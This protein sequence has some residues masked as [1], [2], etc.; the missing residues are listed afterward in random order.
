MP[1][2]FA[3][4]DDSEIEITPGMI[5]A[6]ASVLCG[7]NTYF[8]DEAYWAQETYRAMARAALNEGRCSVIE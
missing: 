6:G 3:N 8:T 5:K 1:E 4:V 7:F 2:G